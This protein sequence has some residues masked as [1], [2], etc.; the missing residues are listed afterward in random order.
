MSLRMRKII[1]CFGEHLQLVD[2]ESFSFLEHRGGAD[3][4]SKIRAAWTRVCAHFRQFSII[5]RY[6]LLGQLGWSM[7]WKPQLAQESR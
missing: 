3:S 5:A 6:R 2:H 4:E 7:L 1:A